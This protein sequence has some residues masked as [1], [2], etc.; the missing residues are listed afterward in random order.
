MPLVI[1]YHLPDNSLG[2]EM[3]FHIRLC[4]VLNGNFGAEGA[5]K[6]LGQPL[7]VNH[8]V[9]IT[10]ALRKGYSKSESLGLCPHSRMLLHHLQNKGIPVNQLPHLTAHAGAISETLALLFTDTV[11]YSGK[12]SN[13]LVERWRDNKETYFACI[14]QNAESNSTA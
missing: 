6:S 4:R 14:S 9:A 3:E 1:F 2:S 10:A 11:L 8:H 12:L 7:T 5:E 13:F